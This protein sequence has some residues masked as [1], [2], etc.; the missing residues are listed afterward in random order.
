MF[1][2]INEEKVPSLTTSVLEVDSPSTDQLYNVLGI[3]RNIP[4]TFL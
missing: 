1:I 2:K 3:K 4:I